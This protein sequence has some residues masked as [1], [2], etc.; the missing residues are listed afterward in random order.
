ML[1]IY[2]NIDNICLEHVITLFIQ[3]INIG[4]KKK[5]IIKYLKE[6]NIELW[7]SSLDNEEMT[8]EDETNNDLIM[9]QDNLPTIKSNHY[10]L[11]EKAS[12]EE[13]ANLKENIENGLGIANEKRLKEIDSN[14]R[15]I[16]KLGYELYK[17][18]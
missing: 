15:T 17:E 11:T 6:K 9:S 10:I 14:F 3:L 1:F 16:R 18:K 13:L 8:E 12:S 4:K 5:E 7:I 2:Y